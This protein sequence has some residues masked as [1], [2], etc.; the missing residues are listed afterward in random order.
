LAHPRQSSIIDLHVVSKGLG[1]TDLH[2]LDDLKV[3]VFIM[4]SV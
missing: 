2:C 4:L 1:F 3:F